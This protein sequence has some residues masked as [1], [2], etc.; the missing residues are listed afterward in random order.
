MMILSHMSYVSPDKLI[1]EFR[2]RAKLYCKGFG[3][4]LAGGIGHNTEDFT[5]TP[6]QETRMDIEESLQTLKDLYRTIPF[7]ELK[8]HPDIDTFLYIKDRISVLEDE[9][10]RV[11]AGDK[12]RVDSVYGIIHDIL[13]KG[14]EYESRLQK[15]QKKIRSY[16]GLSSFKFKTT[17]LE[18]RLWYYPF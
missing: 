3:A 14:S 2:D 8:N 12:S 5:I 16:P 13:K 15:L 18:D 17:D 6:K 7:S 9:T 11:L 1:N 10:K 4:L